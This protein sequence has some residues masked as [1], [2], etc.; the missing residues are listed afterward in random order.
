MKQLPLIDIE[1]FESEVR[2]CLFTH[3]LWLDN[4]WAPRTKG[5]HIRV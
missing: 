5:A 2:Q 1:M 3:D 4:T